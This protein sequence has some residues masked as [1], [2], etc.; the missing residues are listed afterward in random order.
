MFPDIGVLEVQMED[1]AE[2]SSYRNSELGLE[3]DRVACPAMGGLAEI[4]VL[5][6]FFLTLTKPCCSEDFEF[7]F[8]KGSTI[9]L[10]GGVLVLSQASD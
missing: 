4:L 10:V 8:P 7:E 1:E 2:L 3:D 9:L 5:T 6:L